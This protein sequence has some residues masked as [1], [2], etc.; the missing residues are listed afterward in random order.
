MTQW[1]FHESCHLISGYPIILTMP[2]PYKLTRV[3]GLNPETSRVL[4][5]DLWSNRVSNC[6]M[7]YENLYYG[8]LCMSWEKTSCIIYIYTIIYNCGQL[9]DLASACIPASSASARNSARA[10]CLVDA[11]CN[12]VRPRTSH[13][14][15]HQKR[16]ESVRVVEWSLTNQQHINSGKL[17]YL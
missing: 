5:Y 9:W 4:P 13:G 1:Y 17:T 8:I 11:K 6:I 2:V 16:L 12:A 14:Q 3:M 10:V 7:V 15:G